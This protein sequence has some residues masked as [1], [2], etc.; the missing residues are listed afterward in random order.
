LAKP[1]RYTP[2]NGGYWERLISRR[3]ALA[4]AAALGAGAVALA[5]CGGGGD[6][7]ESGGDT[8]GLVTAPADTTSNAKTGGIIQIHA[9][10][11][12]PNLD[13]TTSNSVAA[14]SHAGYQY[15]RL[16][17]YIPGR[18]EPSKGELEGDLA[19]SL[20]EIAND[21]LTFTFKLRQN[22]GTDPRPP[23]NGR[24]LDAQD[25]L[26]SYDRLVALNPQ[27]ADI[28]RT[29]SETAPVER[30]E[31]PD[32]HT[33]V[34][35]L[36]EPYVPAL[37]LFASA[38]HLWVIPREADG[39]FNPEDTSRGSGPWILQNHVPSARF[40]YRR[41]PNWYRKDRPF[42]DGWDIT[43]L[44][45]Y[46]QVQAQLRAKALWYATLRQEDILP[47]K[48]EVPE[49]IIQEN[50]SFVAS[51]PHIMF[52][53]RSGSPFNDE[54]VRE[55]VSM[56]IDREI[57]IDTFWN[58]QGYIDEGIDPEIRWQSHLPTA[59][60]GIWM[61]PR[62][63]EFGANAKYFEHNIDEAKK[64]L[65]AAGFPNGLDT[66]WTYNTTN[67]GVDWPNKNQV[68]VPMMQE[69]GIRA[70]INPVDYAAEYIPN[71]YRGRGDFDGISVSNGG[72]RPDPG[73]WLQ[74]HYHSEGSVG[75]APGAKAGVG[76]IDQE[77]DRMIAAQMREFDREK[78]LSMIKDIQRRTAKTQPVVPMGGDTPGFR[79]PAWPWVM[80]YGVFQEW[81]EAVGPAEV[82]IHL[83][84][85]QSKRTT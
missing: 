8:S 2:R 18:L 60:S 14:Q 52:G 12:A 40:E 1:T 29:R 3:R 84:Y 70:K 69:G 64:L 59:W 61:D 81:P 62:S 24:P 63:N 11:D 19:L 57:Y 78:R 36:A 53:F 56:L 41:N 42:V 31:A 43:I 47:L 17:K 35:R 66:T 48:R 37:V 58:I 26:F 49:I 51:G 6:D 15:S 21:G 30:L 75:H 46:S 65:A 55:A 50:D 34:A 73:L 74:L 32:N 82:G 38:R 16:L 54:R 45:E 67:Y 39:G 72:S 22:D 85:D 80:N 76:Q 5:A 77:L 79:A 10:T 7:G 83:W 71:Y 25:V 20:P 28:S 44:P 13:P 23:T 27:G 33:I 4:G 68:L 9:Q